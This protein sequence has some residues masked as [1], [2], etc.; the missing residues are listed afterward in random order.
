MLRSIVG[1]PPDGVVAIWIDLEKFD[2]VPDWLQAMLEGLRESIGDRKK[3]PAW[4][5]S[6]AKAAKTILSQI[7]EVQVLGQGIKLRR[8]EPGAEL[9]RPMADKLV[10]LL[11]STGLPVIFLLDEFPWF[12]GHVA[13]KHTSEEVEAVLNWFRGARQDLAPQKARFLL[14][15]SIGLEGLLRRLGLSPSANDLDTIE[16][17]PL[18]EDEALGFL[19]ALADGERLSLPEDSCRRILERLGCN[20]PILLSLFVSEIQEA[21]HGTGTSPARIDDIYEN[22]IVRGSRNKYCQEMFTRIGKADV[23]SVAE[24]SI[25]QELLRHLS[26]KESVGKDEIDAIHAKIISPD[27]TRATLAGEMAYVIDTL[28]HDGYILRR[29][30]GRYRFA[31]NVL[32]DYWLHRSV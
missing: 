28:R 1:E 13:R 26:A 31:S 7:E 20:W 27:E 29:R 11:Q 18:E 30:D 25:A 16:I 5:S 8:G 23:F 4:L 14:T 21:G 2:N 12:L 22:Q 6:S 32:R 10:S 3:T 17:P 15:G 19:Q 9:W 24:Q